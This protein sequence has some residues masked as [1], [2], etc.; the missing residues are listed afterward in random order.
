V[1]ARRLK[2]FKVH[3]RT[4]ARLTAAGI[5]HRLAP[6]ATIATSSDQRFAGETPLTPFLA[7]LSRIPQRF[8]RGT[9]ADVIS[10][11]QQFIDQRLLTPLLAFSS[12]LRLLVAGLILVALLPN[13]TLG[14]LFWLGA[15][16][17]PWSRPVTAP[18]ESPIPAAQSAIPPPVTLS[19]CHARSDSRRARNLP[20]CAR[21]Y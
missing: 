14:A 3:L 13:L 5:P 11:D 6:G 4:A 1:A 8:A 12:G 21:W 9:H 20:N 7:F 15:I 18:S 2:R 16:N 17:T 10:S 19:P